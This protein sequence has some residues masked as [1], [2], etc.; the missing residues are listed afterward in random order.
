MN[1]RR[2][3]YAT[4]ADALD[5]AGEIMRI[6]Q[7]GTP[8]WRTW[9]MTLEGYCGNVSRRFSCSSNISS[10]DV[11]DQCHREWAVWVADTLAPGRVLGLEDWTIAPPPE[12]RRRP[13]PSADP[14]AHAKRVG[15]RQS[16]TRVLA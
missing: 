5:I 16:R 10:D 1:L 6:V 7:Y 4:Y 14:I 11:R 2:R 13:E 15:K 8:D 3:W 12:P 9:E